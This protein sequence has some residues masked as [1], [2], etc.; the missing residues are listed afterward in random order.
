MPVKRKASVISSRAKIRRRVFVG[1]SFSS[2][3]APE[4]SWVGDVLG[5]HKLT[6][7]TGGRLGAVKDVVEKAIGGKAKNVS[8]IF[9]GWDKKFNPKIS[10][11]AGNVVVKRNAS[12]IRPFNQRLGL[13]LSSNIGAYA[14]LP[15]E[16]KVFSGTMLEVHTLIHT[17]ILE[18][19]VSKKKNL[20]P[21]IFIGYPWRSTLE[22]M[23]G[24][25]KPADWAKI[26]K[27]IK[28]A[29]TAEELESFLS[30]R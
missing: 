28:Y 12:G 3:I 7:V 6:L 9:K 16:G 23:R 30:R 13:L 4:Y 24:S 1:G 18:A 26:Q 11:K 29:N 22:Y 19:T 17:M 27:Y 8:V 25:Y 21:V 5:R 2:P 15:P 10:G 20:R 14:F